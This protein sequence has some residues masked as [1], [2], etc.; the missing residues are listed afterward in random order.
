[1]L[2]VCSPLLSSPCFALLTMHTRVHSLHL[3]HLLSI[4][5]VA[6]GAAVLLS[7]HGVCQ[8]LLS[9]RCFTS[10]TLCPSWL[11]AACLLANAFVTLLHLA[12][13]AS[14]GWWPASTASIQGI[15]GFSFYKLGLYHSAWCL[16]SGVPLIDKKNII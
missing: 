6:H 15:T 16:L 2:H 11:G 1:M 8:A 7:I 10:L 9:S 12:D 4:L 3:L 5:H 13:D 14:W